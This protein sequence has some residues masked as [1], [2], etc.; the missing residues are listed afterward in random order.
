MTHNISWRISILFCK[1]TVPDM[2]TTNSFRR[3]HKGATI[4]WFCENFIPETS[5]N[6]GISKTKTFFM[7]TAPV[8]YKPL[9][10]IQSSAGRTLHIF[11]RGAG[12]VHRPDNNRT[13][14]TNKYFPFSCAYPCAYISFV[15]Q[16]AY[17]T[18][19][20]LDTD[21]LVGTAAI[22]GKLSMK[23]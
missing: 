2:K 5:R 18:S 21:L 16:Y 1:P 9:A 23:A 4:D 3:N 13:Y 11:L 20:I 8:R 22:R 15:L 6:P 19:V 7:N 14:E 10:C 12:N 17:L